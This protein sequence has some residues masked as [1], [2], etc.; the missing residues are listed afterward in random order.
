MNCFPG[1]NEF[2]YTVGQVVSAPEMGFLFPAFDDRAA[3][4]YNTL[5]YSRKADELHREFINAVFHTEPPMSAVEQREA[6]QSALSEALE[7]TYCVEVVRSIHERLTD[8]IVQHKQSKPP[9]PLVITTGDIGAILQDCGV[10]QERID[11][12]EENCV[13]KFGEEAVLSPANLID[14][15]KFE[16]K[17]AQATVSV[18]PEQSYLVETRTI[19]GKKYILIP[20]GGEVEVNGQTVKFE[21]DLS[22]DQQ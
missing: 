15:G 20:V 5:F 3:N 6:F 17:T 21:A 9:E 16:V 13:E 2:H 7:D 22:T 14:A 19:G 8:Q 4:I 12:F 1:D 18:K 10:S 11:A